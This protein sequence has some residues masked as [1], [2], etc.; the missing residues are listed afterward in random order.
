M[1]PGANSSDI[2]RIAKMAEAGEPAAK[3]SKVLGIKLTAVKSFMP[4]K[5]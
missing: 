2:R 1:K 5:K 3:I 4:A